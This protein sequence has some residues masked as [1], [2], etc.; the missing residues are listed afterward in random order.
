MIRQTPMSED[1]EVMFLG[2]WMLA[3]RYQTTR[4][5]IPINNELLDGFTFLRFIFPRFVNAL[6]VAVVAVFDR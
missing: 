6:Q 1:R 3:D 2:N 5:Q 4:L